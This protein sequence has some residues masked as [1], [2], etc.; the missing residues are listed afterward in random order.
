MSERRDIDPVLSDWPYEPGVIAARLV[1]AGDGR[2]VL[3]MRIELGLLQ[4]ETTG[5]PDGQRPEGAETYLDYLIEQSFNKGDSFELTE[6]Q[7]FEVDREFLQFYHRRVCYLALRKFSEAI[8]DANHTLT[9]M[10]FVAQCSPSA[11]WTASH[12]Q[13]RPFI[14][15]HRTQASAMRALQ[16]PGAETAIEEITDGLEQIRETFAAVDLEEQFGEDPLVGQLEE[17]RDSLRKEH[18]VGLTLGEQLS[19]AVANEQFEQ[20]ARIRDEI[21]RRNDRC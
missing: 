21:A 15:F 17:L 13:Y 16:G 7:C 5:R 19:E 6:D 9:L 20:A 4:I 8:E 12:E 3:Q 1:Q 11:E 14:L 10:D 18:D 2:E